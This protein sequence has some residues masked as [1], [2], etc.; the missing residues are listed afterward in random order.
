MTL[1][2]LLFIPVAIFAVL[3]GRRGIAHVLVLTAVFEGAA[4]VNVNENG[5]SPFYLMCAV[6]ACSLALRKRTFDAVGNRALVYFAVYALA[7]TV[8]AAFAFSGV[9]V[10]APRLGLDSQFGDPTPFVFGISNVAQL[11]YLALGAAGA[12]FLARLV[13]EGEL[14]LR[15]LRG[16]V[17]QAF[18]LAMLLGAW[19]FVS[20]HSE[21]V[22][23]PRAFFGSN[24]S[25]DF[26]GA[27]AAGVPR[28]YGTFTE[29][30]AFAGFLLAGLAFFVAARSDAGSPRQRYAC[31]AVV[32]A[33]LLLVTDSSTARLGL[34][35]AVASFY[36][37]VGLA[38]LRGRRVSRLVLTAVPSAIVALPLA[39][40]YFDLPARV[41][42]AAYGKLGTVSYSVRSFADT[43]SLSL[44]EKT[45]GLGIGLGSNRPSSFAVLLLSSVGV[46]GTGLFVV[47]I[48]RPLIAAY[49]RRDGAAAGLPAGLLTLLGAKVLAIPD[50]STPLLWVLL[51]GC[52]AAAA[53]PGEGRPKT[54]LA[55]SQERTRG[56]MVLKPPAPSRDGE[57]YGP[58]RSRSLAQ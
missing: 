49:K 18:A 45:Y 35:L 8:F 24:E 6:A 31:L 28:L 39:L 58:T 25:R 34:V 5:I 40:F 2:G 12:W 33:S 21:S 42:E 43:Y 19:Q 29:P 26:V 16:Y 37:L 32:A 46:I 11:V 52:M 1:F 50:L 53:A 15:R 27:T 3:Y 13:A 56:S 38:L 30:S 44:I 22:S 54:P 7:V 47:A 9:G 36:P 41:A 51:G 48:V 4:V 10:L 17:G 14:P 57:K 20:L 23:W 55:V